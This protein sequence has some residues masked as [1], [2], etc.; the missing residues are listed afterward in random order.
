MKRLFYIVLLIVAASG[1]YFG[2][3]YFFGD[4]T[5]STN[6]SATLTQDGFLQIDGGTGKLNYK[7]ITDPAKTDY[8][9]DVYAGALP[10]NDGEYLSAQYQANGV[11]FTSGTFTTQDDVATVSKYYKAKLGAD[12]QSTTL[13]LEGNNVWVGRAKSGSPIVEV[14]SQNNKT[15]IKIIKR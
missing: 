6:E 4:K 5:A 7:A 10:V 13:T 14:F 3:I 2:Y 11:T 15:Y 1:I 9:I 8:G 12:A